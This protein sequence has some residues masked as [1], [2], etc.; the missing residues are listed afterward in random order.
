M[1]TTST[2]LT[3]AQRK[4]L[5]A[6][7][8]PL[9]PVVTV[10]GAGLTPAVLREVERALVAHALIKV[11]VHGDDRDARI[12]VLEAIVAATGAAAVQHIGKL[13]VLWRPRP[14]PE[15]KDHVPKKLAALGRAA[16]PAKARGKAPAGA[17]AGARAGTK[18]SRAKGLGRTGTGGREG[19][20]YG[21]AAPPRPGAPPK[22][23]TRGAVQRTADGPPTDVAGR[24]GAGR[25]PAGAGRR[26]AP[27]ARPPAGPPPRPTS[28]SGAGPATR[29]AARPATRRTPRK[30]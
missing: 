17:R 19:L 4:A 6:Q 8:H 1:T 26:A 28:R 15:P 14:E 30:G 9:D 7:A 21:G 25:K 13:L 24:A 12:A 10:G 5:K 16:A 18:V 29:S 20:G 2:A 3:P 11:R 27:A 22:R 23:K